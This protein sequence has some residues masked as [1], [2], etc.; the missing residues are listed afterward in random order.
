MS[1]SIARDEVGG[2]AL[3]ASIPFLFYTLLTYLSFLGLVRANPVVVGLS[4]C[5]IIINIT[6]FVGFISTT[7]L[8]FALSFCL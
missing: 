6:L 8:I 3:C 5:L 2:F 7:R 4:C 1:A